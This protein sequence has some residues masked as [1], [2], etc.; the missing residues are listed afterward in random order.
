MGPLIPLVF[1]VCFFVFFLTSGDVYSEFQA[2]VAGAYMFPEIHLWCDTCRP[3][4]GQHS[5]FEKLFLL[6]V[7][8]MFQIL[9]HLIHSVKHRMSKKA[10][11]ELKE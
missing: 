11:R 5:H 9:I 2:R 3:L 7:I 6:L 8:L 4:D 1:F 10:M